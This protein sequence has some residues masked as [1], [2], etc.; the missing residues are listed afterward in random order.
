MM[1][2]TNIMSLRQFARLLLKTILCACVAGLL[3]G[4]SDARAQSGARSV[5]AISMGGGTSVLGA[6]SAALYTNPAA[7]TV[8][9]SDAAVEIRLLDVRAYTGGDL[10]Q[11]KHYNETLASGASLTD[12]EIDRHLDA[13]FGEAQ[14][15]GA[16]Y[17]AVVPVAVSYRPQNAQWAVGAGLRMQALSKTSMNRGMLDLLLRGTKPE[18][19]LPVDGRY[20]AFSTVDLTGAFSYAFSSLPLSVGVAPRLLLGTGY[21]D[22]RLDSVV[23]A[24]ADALTHTFDYTARA[25]GAVSREVYDTF[26]AFAAE[27]LQGSGMAQEIAGVGGG[28][29]L[30]AT[31]EMR[32]GLY[33]SMS[34]TDLGAIRWSGDAQT[35]TP[36]NNQFQFDG[37]SF[38]RKRLTDEF[39]GQVWDYVKH[40]VD[41]LARAAYEDVERDRSTFTTGLPTALHVSGTWSQ[42]RY[43]LVSGATMGLNSEAGAVHSAPAVHAGGEAQFG[44]VP[45]RMGVRFGGP[46]AVTVAGGLGLEL[47]GYRFDVG[48][49]VTP[50]TNLLGRGARYAVGLSLA[51]IRF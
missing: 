29:D 44:P 24:K 5:E 18:R 9:S 35:V 12:E 14:R 15:Q 20:R 16:A 7:L 6:R 19:T 40:E 50:S 48:A 39:D 47:S 10:F 34:L 41:S 13:W 43:T 42:G 17:G 51:T 31:Y 46:H 45:L 11:F 3:L 36:V 26:N 23:E 33:L 4:A 30:G 38:D 22:G 28:V 2:L 1:K 37:V 32:S 25:S 49:S 8:G 21:A 27:P